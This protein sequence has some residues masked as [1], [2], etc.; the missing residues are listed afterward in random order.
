MEK[1]RRSKKVTPPEQAVLISG[2]NH[3]MLGK[4]HTNKQIN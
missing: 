4:K 2:A 1:L 3:P